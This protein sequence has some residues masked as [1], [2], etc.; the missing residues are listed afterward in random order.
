MERRQLTTSL[1]TL[2]RSPLCSEPLTVALGFFF[3][4]FLFLFTKGLARLFDAET[5]RHGKNTHSNPGLTSCAQPLLSTFN[6]KYCLNSWNQTDEPPQGL[7]G[8]SQEHERFGRY[9]SQRGKSST[10]RGDVGF[11]YPRGGGRRGWGRRCHTAVRFPLC[12]LGPCPS[13][14]PSP[15]SMPRPLS[16]CVCVC[17]FV[18]Q[19]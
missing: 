5:H 3:F 4:F 2:P 8:M 19:T 13:C 14:E 10:G 7:A 16:I 18:S 11:M 12:I 6:P 1:F 17:V 9:V 15:Y